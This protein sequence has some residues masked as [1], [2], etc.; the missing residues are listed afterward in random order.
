VFEN[1]NKNKRRL[2][3]HER[4][5]KHMSTRGEHHLI[6]ASELK[7][8]LSKV[9]DDAGVAFVEDSKV[10]QFL[11]ITPDTRPGVEGV[12]AFNLRLLPNY[13]SPSP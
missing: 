12:F 8:Q 1:R 6:S 9:P 5:G 4:G 13:P 7:E 3:I 11:G 10:F 2:D